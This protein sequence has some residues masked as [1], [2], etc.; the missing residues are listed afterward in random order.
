MRTRVV[1]AVS[2]LVL[3]VHVHVAEAQ[4]G[5]VP[6]PPPMPPAMTQGAPSPPNSLEL[7]NQYFDAS[8]DGIH[9]LVDTYRDDDPKL[10]R[11]L[12]RRVEDLEGMRTRAWAIGLST[13]AVGVGLAVGGFALWQQQPSGLGKPRDLTPLWGPILG[14]PLVLF[15]Y[16][17]GSAFGPHRDDYLSFVNY[18]NRIHPENPIHWQIGLLPSHRPSVAGVL[19]LDLD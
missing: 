1:V 19:S 6:P 18:H 4:P 9:Q 15:S 8:I 16:Y 7:S 10:Y 13:A 3:A 12:L 17:I 14:V 5:F 2:P 11:R